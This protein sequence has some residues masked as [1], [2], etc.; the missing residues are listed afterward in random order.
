MTD[1]NTTTTDDTIASD[2]LAQAFA[3]T[4][5]ALAGKESEKL[6]EKSDV[7]AEHRE[8]ITELADKIERLERRVAAREE[9]RARRR[10]AVA[11]L[12]DRVEQL[13]KQLTDLEKTHL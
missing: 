13:D 2:D 12:V 3:E 7:P 5:R 6:V 8:W 10:K 4:G 1:T 9:K 11:D